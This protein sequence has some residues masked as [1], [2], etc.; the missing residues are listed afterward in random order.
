VEEYRQ[1]NINFWMHSVIGL[2][3]LTILVTFSSYSFPESLEFSFSNDKV[4]KLMGIFLIAIALPF[5]IG[6]AFVFKVL[7]LENQKINQLEKNP[8]IKISMSFGLV[9]FVLGLGFLMFGVHH[10]VGKAFMFSSVLAFAILPCYL[11]SGGYIEKPLFK[12]K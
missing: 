8:V 5:N 11:Y 10:L 7:P 9:F 4:L 2:A 1:N 6:L 3:S 12:R